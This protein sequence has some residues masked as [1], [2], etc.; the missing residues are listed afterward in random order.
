MVISDQLKKIYECK[1]K[2]ISRVYNGI[3]ITYRPDKNDPSIVAQINKFRDLNYKIIGSYAYLTRIKGL[4]QLIKVLE[5]RKDLAVVIIGE[6][7]AKNELIEL[8][9]TLNV[10]DRTLFWIIYPLHIIIY[11]FLM[12]MRCVHVV[13]VLDL[14]RSKLH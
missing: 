7:E 1:L 14:Q 2:S 11:P 4:E 10:I 3:D 8:S 5:K 6:G 13:K 9:R 12:S